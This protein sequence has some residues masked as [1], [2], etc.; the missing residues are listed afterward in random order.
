M[1]MWQNL[2]DKVIF[3]KGGFVGIGTTTP[4]KK[5]TVIG[6]IRSASG[7]AETNYLEMDHGGT[8]AYVKLEWCRYDGYS[9]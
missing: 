8:N 5:L 2:T 1:T 7:T 4:G 6:P 3:K 9:I